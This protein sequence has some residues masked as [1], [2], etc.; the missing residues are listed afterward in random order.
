MIDLLDPA[1]LTVVT[2]G[3]GWFGRAF[4][5]AIATG[6][7]DETGPVARAGPVRVLVPTPSDVATVTAVLPTAEVHVGD[8][9]D[10]A[11]VHRLLS[12]GQG[13][14][15][16]HAAT[17][18][19]ARRASDFERDNV[20]GTANVLDAARH[21]R[22]RRVVHVSTAFVG[23]E[24]R[25]ADRRTMLPARPAHRVRVGE[26]A[27]KLTAERAVLAANRTGV[28]ETV[29][30]RAPACY[31]PWQPDEQTD[32]LRSVRAGRYPIVGP[33]ERL[34]S[35]VYVDNLVQAVALA[36]RVPCATGAALSVADDSPYPMRDVIATLKRAL[37]DEGL[38]VSERQMRLPA[39]VAGAAKR[40]GVYLQERGVSDRRVRV[41]ATMDGPV[42]V[43]NRDA[44]RVLGYDP[45]VELLEGTRRSI[46]WCVQQGLEL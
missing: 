5:N 4:L 39:V 33:G 16:V 13:A 24:Q 2:G 41:L 37:R 45:K 26:T 38:E 1:L 17:A 20:G 15:V 7:T 10:L 43:D 23:A 31:G 34:R 8:V 18:G 35:L 28:L 32:F 22:A 25:P 42:V 30:I 44:A 40:A 12:D 6:E 27:S 21:V 29:V 3:G 11:A 9:A 36:E 14:S 46:R 19:H